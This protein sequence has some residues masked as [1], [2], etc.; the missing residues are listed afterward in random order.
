MLYREF[1]F[2]NEFEEL[3]PSTFKG[4]KEEFP[5]KSYIQLK[6]KDMVVLS[7]IKEDSEEFKYLSN[8][9]KKIDSILQPQNKTHPSK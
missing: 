5:S 1:N 9:I 4:T 3:E 6:G 2:E 8:L 7:D